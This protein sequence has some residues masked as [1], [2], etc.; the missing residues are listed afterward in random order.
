VGFTGVNKHK[1][2]QTLHEAV[3]KKP[4]LALALLALL[5][6]AAVRTHGFS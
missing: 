3:V 6:A 2:T 4:S 5:G 1:K